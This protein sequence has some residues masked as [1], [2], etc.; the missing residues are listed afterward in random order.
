MFEHRFYRQK[1]RCKDLFE[2]R[3]SIAETD[4]LALA[5]TDLSEIAF[6]FTRRL[7]YKI[8]KYIQ[9]NF[10]FLKTLE[11]QPPDTK[12]PKIIQD[13]QKASVAAGVGPM[14]SV[15]GVI[16]EY[17]GN[18]LRKK[19]KE[20]IVENGGDIYIYTK[21]E[22][23]IQIYAGDSPLSGKIAI[24][25]KPRNCPLGICASS[26]TVGH[27]LSFGITDA[28]CVIS[29]SACLA[30]AYAT[31]LGNSIKDEKTIAEKLDIFI[32]QYKDILGALVIVGDKLAYAGDIE[33]VRI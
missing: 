12:A 3:I 4:I 6:R 5:D 30:D 2:F 17:L 25:V 33:V 20:V 21:K 31:S 22:R 16:A 24:K 13:M 18:A 19:S 11:P 9:F 10:S 28:T 23:L 7:R 27:S 1:T 26:A 14:A 29:K 8:E 32:E 15:A